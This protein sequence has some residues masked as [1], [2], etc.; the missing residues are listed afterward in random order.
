M[1]ALFGSLKEAEEMRDRDAAACGLPKTE[2]VRLGK[3][4]SVVAD[5]KFVAPIVAHPDGKTWGYPATE[6]V[7]SCVDNG[8]PIVLR[9][10]DAT[11]APPPPVTGAEL[12]K[13]Q[14]HLDSVEAIRRER[15][16]G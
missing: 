9:K 14:Q 1:L 15:S 10:P 7:L 5:T 3:S 6:F 4:R 11:W 13:T 12:V 2:I 16:N 8:E